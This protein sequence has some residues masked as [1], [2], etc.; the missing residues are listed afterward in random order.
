M[1][2]H[3][4]AKTSIDVLEGKV[5]GRALVFFQGALNNEIILPKLDNARIGYFPSHRKENLRC[6]GKG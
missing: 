1:L 5:S 6:E 2:H 4:A 3:M